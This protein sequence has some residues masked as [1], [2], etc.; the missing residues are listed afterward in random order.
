MN[1]RVHTLAELE[2][3]IVA[4][5]NALGHAQLMLGPMRA[6]AKINGARRNDMEKK[7]AQLGDLVDERD[8]EIVRL[9]SLLT[10]A[11]VLL[12]NTD[13]PTPALPPMRD[14]YFASYDPKDD[15]K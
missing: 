4:A 1:T 15:G 11:Y 10:T 3:T 14:E 2:H 12:G 7:I 5:A 9:R 8:K 13:G 6:N